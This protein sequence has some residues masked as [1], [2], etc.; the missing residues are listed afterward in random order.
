[1]NVRIC[2]IAICMFATWGQLRAAPTTGTTAPNATVNAKSLEPFFQAIAQDR[3]AMVMAGDSNQLIG[4]FGW[5]D[6]VE[7][8]WGDRFE[9]Y[10][11]GLLS[12]A[13]NKGLGAASGY[14]YASR[15]DTTGVMLPEGAL[16]HSLLLPQQT[17]SGFLSP[18]GF[19]TLPAGVS[20]STTKLWGL[21]IFKNTIQQSP[22]FALPSAYDLRGHITYRTLPQDAGGQFSPMWDTSLIQ[23]IQNVIPP[24]V[25][26][27]PTGKGYDTVSL[28]LP[29]SNAA[30]AGSNGFFRLRLN[31]KLTMVNNISGPL[32]VS[33][34]QIERPGARG[35]SISTLAWLGGQGF[36]EMATG[37]QLGSIPYDISVRQ[38]LSPLSMY[39]GRMRELMTSPKIL[40]RLYFGGNDIY[41][42]RVSAEE[43]AQSARLCIQQLQQLWFQ[44]GWDASELYFLL[45][46]WHVRPFGDARESVLENPALPQLRQ[47]LGSI[48]RDTPRTAFVDMSV[49]A[50]GAEMLAQNWW[51]G[52]VGA[53]TA[54]LTKEGYT[55]LAKRELD[56]LEVRLQCTSDLNG[57]F[58]VDSL[59]LGMLLGSW[60]QIDYANDLNHD[61]LVDS[62]D[63]GKLL[64]QWGTCVAIISN[65]TGGGGLT[66]EEEKVLFLPHA[67]HPRN[68]R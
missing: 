53:G 68:Q 16:S 2:S 18:L 41:A 54:H 59:D 37:I 22:I 42:K 24:M 4:A 60:G 52:L 14:L 28:D 64:G 7:S 46:G 35:I 26:V 3:A 9:M 11:T 39:F 55:A 31:H 1:M 38:A 61:G 6:G 65:P 25:L 15:F 62:T 23:G 48:A 66:P 43:A 51:L 21:D 49:L 47:M 44:Q 12:A 50:P 40:I 5:G 19:A 29:Y 36:A 56:A 58:V 57:D 45:V 67:Q 20:S 8:V 17:S 63:L 13:E 10:A 34:Y 33:F 32:F 27:S 30:G